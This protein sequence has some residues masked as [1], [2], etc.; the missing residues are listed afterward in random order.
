MSC[1]GLGWTLSL[2]AGGE[3][4]TIEVLVDGCGDNPRTNE[5]LDLDGPSFAATTPRLSKNFLNSYLPGGTRSECQRREDARGVI[6]PR[7]Y[8]SRS[9]SRSCSIMFVGG[10]FLISSG[11]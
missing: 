9:L 7:I 4:D 3:G 11:L 2:G 6:L 1:D 5:S 10:G 8:F